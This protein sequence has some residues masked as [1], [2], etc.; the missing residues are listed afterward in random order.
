M[1]DIFIG[2]QGG[3]PFLRKSRF[4]ALTV[5]RTVIHYRSLRIPLNL[6]HQSKNRLKR[7]FFLFGGQ[8]GIRTHEPVRTT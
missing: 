7:R 1:A 5:P 2:G 6:F 4:A 3:I 8:G